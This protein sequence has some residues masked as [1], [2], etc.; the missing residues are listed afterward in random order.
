MNHL[1]KAN[2]GTL[3]Q[4]ERSSDRWTCRDKAAACCLFLPTLST[5]MRLSR[6]VNH[7][8]PNEQLVAGGRCLS[9][10]R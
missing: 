3:L 8:R 5:S 1:T 4:R 9:S 10:L 6:H 2:S 7:L